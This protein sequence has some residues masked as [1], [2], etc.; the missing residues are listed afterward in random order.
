MSKVKPAPCRPTRDRRLSHYPQ[1]SAGG[2]GVVYLA[3]DKE[4]QQVAVKEY[5]PSSL[6]MRDAGELVPR[7]RPRSCRC[8]AWA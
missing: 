4:G 5:L 7:C 8:T 1:I 3:L 6:A 2:F